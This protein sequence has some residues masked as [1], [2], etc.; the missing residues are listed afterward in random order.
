MKSTHEVEVVKVKLEPHDNAD[1]LSIVNIDG[2][3]V[4]VR[5]ADWKDGDL[6]A[7]IKP[8]S[9]VNTD[10]PEFA[11][12]ANNKNNK[13]RIKVKKLRGVVSM[14]LLVPAPKGSKEG[15]NVANQLEVEHYE[16]ELK[17]TTQDDNV[18]APKGYYPKYDIDSIRKYNK[19]FDEGELVCISE[20]IHG[21]NCR[22]VFLNEMYCGSRNNWKKESDT[23]LWWRALR[24]YPQI[25][26][27]CRNNPGT[28][29]YGEVFGQ[30]QDLKYGRNEVDFVAFDIMNPQGKYLNVKGFLQIC[31]ENLIPTV[32]ILAIDFPFDY[33]T[34]EALSNGPSQ[35]P[36]A[37]CVREGVVVKPM[38]E[39]WNEE[40][41]R[42]IL[43]LIGNDYYLRKTK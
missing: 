7:Y 41:G 33:G 23:N 26:K 12:L 25:E 17:L 9:I 28:V 13:Q 27:F 37:D 31:E 39:Q 29:I 18:P 20:K 32:P 19:I 21:A 4:C 43:K 30:V 6:G 14:G 1:S 40:I 16:P 36:G 5:T 11:F 38:L 8:D 35:V 42:K 3:T 15:D 34:I 22:Y 2:Y 24:K 10:R